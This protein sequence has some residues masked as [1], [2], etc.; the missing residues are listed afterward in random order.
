MP[1]P[2]ICNNETNIKECDGKARSEFACRDDG[3]KIEEN[4]MEQ[5][6]LQDNSTP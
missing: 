4:C 1:P 6:A 3:K 2:N 5:K